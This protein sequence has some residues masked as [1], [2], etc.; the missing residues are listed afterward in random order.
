M[1]DREQ[2]DKRDEPRRDGGPATIVSE[3]TRPSNPLCF[4]SSPAVSALPL[5]EAFPGTDVRGRN[6]YR[7]AATPYEDP[8][9]EDSRNRH[10]SLG[11]GDYVL[12]HGATGFQYGG[13]QCVPRSMPPSSLPIP[14]SGTCATTEGPASP[15]WVDGRQDPPAFL[16]QTSEPDPSPNDKLHPLGDAHAD[17]NGSSRVRALPLTPQ[18]HLHCSRV[19]RKRPTSY[20]APEPSAQTVTGSNVLTSASVREW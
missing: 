16:S 10:W 4:P 2:E 18:G 11:G 19:V 15:P 14:R 12:A 5:Q 7:T 8:A 17:A 6:E 20:P 3:S 1:P 9:P 13:D